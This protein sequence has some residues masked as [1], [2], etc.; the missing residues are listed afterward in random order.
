MP[1]LMNV[2]TSPPRIAHLIA[3][4]ELGGLEQCAA[5]WREGRNR[6]HPASTA[7]L[8]LESAPPSARTITSAPDFCLNASRARFPWD[9]AAVRRLQGYFN[10]HG[11][12]LVHSHNTAARQYAALATRGSA[13]RHVHTDHGSN[14]HLHGI[15]NRLRLRFMNRFTDIVVAVSQVAA[16]QLAQA[17]SRP[18]PS[19]PV[20]RNG[21]DA[22]PRADPASRD[23]IRASWGIPPDAA[24]FGSIGRLSPEKGYDRLVRAMASLPAT[25]ALVLI[26]D[27]PQRAALMTLCRELSLE[28]RVH[29]AG[30]MP[31]ARSLLSAV[32]LFVLPSRSEGLP[33]ALLEAMAEGVPV[34]ATNVGECAEV[35][36]GGAFGMILPDEDSAWPQ[37]LLSML[38]TL[39]ASSLTT[40]ARACIINDY[41]LEHTLDAY[42]RCYGLAL[43]MRVRRSMS[44]A[45]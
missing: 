23:A 34:A 9:R 18:L 45:I 31:D 36:A 21:I 27:G 1:A 8:A 40:A 11:I 24:V 3:S 35:L 2:M 14:P 43:N 19:I 7:L 42:E 16:S 17:S 20:I 25:T 39:P 29:F 22:T 33:L 41:G 44:S 6:R 30:A 28:S 10:A 32:D 13:V 26:G 37:V 15:V 5:L 38:A 12:A 4:P